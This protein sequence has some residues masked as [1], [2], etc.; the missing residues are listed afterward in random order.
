MEPEERLP[1][2]RKA[3]GAQVALSWNREVVTRNNNT[4]HPCLVVGM[5]KTLNL[6]TSINWRASLVPVAAVIPAPKAKIKYMRSKKLVVWFLP[7]T[8]GPPL[9]VSIWMALGI[10]SEDCFC[11]SL[12]GAVFGTF[13]WRKLESF[14]DA[15]V[16]NS[17]AWNNEIGLV[18]YFIGLR[19]TGHD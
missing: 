7:R 19:A 15:L 13:T 2:P 11:S 9:R 1:L 14:K 17:L 4:A 3:A 16:V 6:F 12:C 8:V 10:F 18:A 5:S